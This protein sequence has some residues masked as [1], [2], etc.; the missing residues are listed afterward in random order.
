LYS[1]QA[2]KHPSNYACKQ[3]RGEFDE[4]SFLE[5]TK[6]VNGSRKTFPQNFEAAG[7]PS[8]NPGRVVDF[9]KVES[10]EPAQRFNL[11]G[12]FLGEGRQRLRPLER[13]EVAGQQGRIGAEEG[14]VFALWWPMRYEDRDSTSAPGDGCAVLACSVCAG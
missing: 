1:H 3:K 13:S 12:R 2:K 5:G 4:N 9:G 7:Q 10:S 14:E 11:R 6:P 8:T